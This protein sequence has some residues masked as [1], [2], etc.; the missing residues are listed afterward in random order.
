MNTKRAFGKEYEVIQIRES[1][2]IRKATIFAEIALLKMIS[3]KCRY[4]IIHLTNAN[5]EILAAT[6]IS[7]PPTTGQP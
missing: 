6:E 3:K 4:I 7:V 1:I 5:N 2:P